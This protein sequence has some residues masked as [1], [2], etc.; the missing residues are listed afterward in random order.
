MG[1]DATIH[2]LVAP[3][4]AERALVGGKEAFGR[5]GFLGDAQRNGYGYLG[6]GE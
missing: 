2:Q 6:T 5:P 3:R 1:D 4:V